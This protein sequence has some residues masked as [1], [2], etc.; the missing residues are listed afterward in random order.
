MRRIFKARRDQAEAL[1]LVGTVRDGDAPRG[2]AH[3]L[4]PDLIVADI[5]MPTELV[6]AIRMIA[7]GGT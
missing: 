4:K 2:A 3:I 5:S 1:Q 6:Q 7:G